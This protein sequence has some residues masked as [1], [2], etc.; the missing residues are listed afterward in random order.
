M[1]SLTD[2]QRKAYALIHNQLTNNTEFDLELLHS[3]LEEITDIDMQFFGFDPNL[4][5]K[6]DDFFESGVQAKPQS[7]EE[8]QPDFDS[9]LLQVSVFVPPE[10][11]EHFKELMENNNF[12][13]EEQ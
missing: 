2:Q 5:Q 11:V 13:Y 4:D 1:D 6:L 12:D 8:Q 3:R 9:E 7:E 10:E